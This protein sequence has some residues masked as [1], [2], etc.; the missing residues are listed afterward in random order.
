MKKI[1][2]IVNLTNKSIKRKEIKP[3]YPHEHIHKPNGKT[4]F[5]CPA[6]IY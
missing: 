1:K 3:A 5:N 4:Y 6:G 2:Y